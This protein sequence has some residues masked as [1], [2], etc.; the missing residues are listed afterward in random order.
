M[1][2]HG[3]PLRKL[4]KISEQYWPESRGSKLSSFKLHYESV[5]QLDRGEGFHLQWV[6]LKFAPS[7]NKIKLA[8]PQLNIDIVT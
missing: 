6:E 7:T 3:A 2:G 8:T 4:H 1:I 5:L